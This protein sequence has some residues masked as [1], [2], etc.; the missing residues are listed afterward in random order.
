MPRSRGQG[1]LFERLVP[2]AQPRRT[3]SRQEL[4]AERI[5]A[6]KRHLER[7]LNSRR[8]CSMSSPELGLHDFNDAAMGSADLL[9]HVSQDIRASVL[10]FEPRI[11][12]LHV[13]SRPDPAQPLSLNFRLECLVPV[14]NH[15]EQ[16]EI[17]LVIHHQDRYARVV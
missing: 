15:E 5:H 4:A 16:V 14:M 11:K 10:A 3:R 13:H 8:G 12:V 7:I 1:S 6:I 17:D 9:A 2:D